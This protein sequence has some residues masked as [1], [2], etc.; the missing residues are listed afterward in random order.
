M[1]EEGPGLWQRNF[2]VESFLLVAPG[3]SIPRD[4]AI[5]V[6]GSILVVFPGLPLTKPAPRGHRGL[7]GGYSWTAL[8]PL[9]GGLGQ[10][11]P[12]CPGRPQVGAGCLRTSVP[13]PTVCFH[14]SVSLIL[15]PGQSVLLTPCPLVV[16]RP[17]TCP[18]VWGLGEEGPSGRELATPGETGWGRVLTSPPLLPRMRSLL[19]FFFFLIFSPDR[20]ALCT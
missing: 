18:L 8:G 9:S 5:R 19:F 15:L 2:T 13:R 17:G 7:H 16:T 4:C 10:L 11:V 12:S 3:M 14:E 6:G 20:V 1:R